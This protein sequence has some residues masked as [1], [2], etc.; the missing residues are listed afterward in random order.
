MSEQRGRGRRGKINLGNPPSFFSGP[1]WSPD[2]K[3]IAYSDKRLQL[4]YV[5]LDHPTPKLVDA[6]YFGGFGPTQLNQT[7]A[8]DSK[9]I[10]YTKQLPSGRHASFIFRLKQNQPLPTTPS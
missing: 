8:P 5:D 3:K 6:D 9:R 7:W 1:T 2:S 10:A 4:W